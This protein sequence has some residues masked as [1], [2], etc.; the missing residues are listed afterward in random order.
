M[1]YSSGPGIRKLVFANIAV[2][3]SENRDELSISSACARLWISVFRK[4][5]VALFSSPLGENK[6]IH[7]TSSNLKAA[8]SAVD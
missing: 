4:D 6:S 7:T 3:V 2:S 1:A 8:R 5:S